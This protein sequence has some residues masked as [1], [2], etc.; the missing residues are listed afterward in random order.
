MQPKAKENVVTF[1]HHFKFHKPFVLLRRDKNLSFVSIFHII[2][3]PLSKTK[4]TFGSYLDTKGFRSQC[5]R[6]LA[7][8]TTFCIALSDFYCTK[9]KITGFTQDIICTASG[10]SATVVSYSKI[11]LLLSC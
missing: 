4:E 5:F 9:T 7:D 10:N 2:A 1:D 3:T 6:M 8:V 11:F